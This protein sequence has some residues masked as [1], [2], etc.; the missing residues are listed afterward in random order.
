MR[1]ALRQLAARLIYEA[2][3]RLAYELWPRKSGVV[4]ELR[5][6]MQAAE[7]ERDQ[8]LEERAHM[9][10]EL[11]ES[12]RLHSEL[13]NERP[14]KPVCTRTIA[15][16]L[17]ESEFER[18]RHAVEA[19]GDD[20][21]TGASKVRAWCKRALLDCVAASEEARGLVCCESCEN[22]VPKEVARLDAED[23]VYIC[24]ACDEPTGVPS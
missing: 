17:T 4:A 19:S 16:V 23:G 18:L 2:R 21:L 6:R 20:G 8:L 10:E 15:H 14:A 24:K 12:I 22:V 7:A 5:V 9:A 3:L 13:A 11:R 1:T